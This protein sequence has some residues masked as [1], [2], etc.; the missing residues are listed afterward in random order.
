MIVKRTIRELVYCDDCTEAEARA[1]PFSNA[2]EVI[3]EECLSMTI[4]S[5]S[6]VAA[7]DDWRAVR[8]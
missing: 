3:E 1:D 2:D 4:E 6:P 5:V 8:R 7:G